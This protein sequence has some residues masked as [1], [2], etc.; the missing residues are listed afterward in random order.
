MFGSPKLNFGAFLHDLVKAYAWAKLSH[1][2]N[3]KE[4][5]DRFV[6]VWRECDPEDVQEGEKLFSTLMATVPLY[7]QD[8]IT[9][10]VIS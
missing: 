5:R 8:V 7:R 10:S 9:R 1:S 2:R 4:G 3:Y 6:D